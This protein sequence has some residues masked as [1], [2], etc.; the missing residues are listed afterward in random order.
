MSPAT[1]VASRDTLIRC[2]AC[3][4]MV[5]LWPN[6]HDGSGE[7]RLD[8]PECHALTPVFA[9]MPTLTSA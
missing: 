1:A 9:R 5:A 6:V 3:R 4:H 2:Q 7:E 8:C